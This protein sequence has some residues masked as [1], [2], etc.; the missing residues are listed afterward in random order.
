MKFSVCLLVVL[1]GLVSAEE[2]LL[3]EG[4]TLNSTQCVYLPEN[5][6]FNCQGPS[7]TVE[8]DAVVDFSGLGERQY[9]VY[10]IGRVQEVA[11]ERIESLRIPLYPRNLDNRTY[12]NYSVPVQGR[13]VDVVLYYSENFVEYGIRVQS[14]KCYERIVRLFRSVVESHVGELEGSEE[15]VNLVGE[16]L[17]NDRA[18]Q[19]RWL[20]GYGFGYGYPYWGWGGLGYGYPYWGWG[21]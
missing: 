11:G 3:S 17:I 21:K 20:Y 18:V 13:F 14:L 7:G 10:G 19:K 6:M 5:K 1:L 8:C 16:V 15:D 4:Q 12:A 9:H 2:S